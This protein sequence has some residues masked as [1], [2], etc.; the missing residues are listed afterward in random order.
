MGVNVV[1][2]IVTA[3]VEEGVGTAL[4][5]LYVSRSVMLVVVPSTYMDAILCSSPKS[6]S[7]FAIAFHKICPAVSVIHTFLPIGLGSI[8]LA[9]VPIPLCCGLHES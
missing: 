6:I 8:Y 7:L 2:P 5:T 1:V 9:I 4:D 3:A